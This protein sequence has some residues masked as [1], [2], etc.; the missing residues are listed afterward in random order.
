ML[1]FE[2]LSLFPEIFSSFLEESLIN[3][4]IEQRHLQVDLVN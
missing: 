4:A 2:V 3:R 1:H